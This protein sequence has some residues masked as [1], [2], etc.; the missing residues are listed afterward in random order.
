[1]TAPGSAGT[2]GDNYRCPPPPT[3][4]AGGDDPREPGARRLPAPTTRGNR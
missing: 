3:T 2:A 4:P 1:M